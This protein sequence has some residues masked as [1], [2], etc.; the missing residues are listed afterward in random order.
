MAKENLNRVTKLKAMRVSQK[1]TLEQ[2]SKLIGVRRPTI[3]AQEKKGIFDI[4]TAEKYAKAFN[5]PA[6]FLLERLDK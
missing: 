3:C 2:V 4:R 6:F 5:C 1:M